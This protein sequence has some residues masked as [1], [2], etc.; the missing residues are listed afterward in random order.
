[1]QVQSLLT[2]WYIGVSRCG[3]S[4]LLVPEQLLRG[5]LLG[6]TSNRSVKICA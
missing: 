6:A 2:L 1:M 3:Q 4:L 5:V